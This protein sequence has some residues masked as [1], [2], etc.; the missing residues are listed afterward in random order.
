MYEEWRAKY[1]ENDDQ[2]MQID[3]NSKPSHH[4]EEVK[5]PYQH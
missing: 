3:E 5:V 1:K 4:K 2:S